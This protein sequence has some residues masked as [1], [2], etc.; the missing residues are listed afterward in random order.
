MRTLVWSTAF[1]RAFKRLLRRRSELRE[2]LERVFQLL[3][4]DPFNRELCT[5]KLKGELSG[6]WACT[7]NYDYRILFDF[8]RNPESDEEEIFLLALGTHDEVY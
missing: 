8:V 3:A 6:V 1:S 4:E 5:H 2:R 7:V